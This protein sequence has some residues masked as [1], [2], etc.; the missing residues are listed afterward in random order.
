MTWVLLQEF[1]QIH[2]SFGGPNIM[3]GKWWE[4]YLHN[5][6]TFTRKL[7]RFWNPRPTSTMILMWP[8]SEHRPSTLVVRSPGLLVK[9]PA[10]R[11]A[12]TS[13]FIQMTLQPNIRLDAFLSSPWVRRGTAG[14]K[15]HGRFGVSG[16]HDILIWSAQ[17]VKDGKPPIEFDSTYFNFQVAPTLFRLRKFQQARSG[18]TSDSRF[19]PGEESKRNEKIL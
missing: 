5:L 4:S 10:R 14:R 2:C 7:G 11:K 16:G 12:M 17:D 15:I 9:S 13:P 18:E 8:Q 19:Y 3:D 1:L 6:E